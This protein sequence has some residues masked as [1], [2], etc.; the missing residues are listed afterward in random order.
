MSKL[1]EYYKEF[2]NENKKLKMKQKWMSDFS[3]ALPSQ[4]NVNWDHATYH[5]NKGTPPKEA[6]KTH[7]PVKGR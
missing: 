5:F 2:V 6:A 7:T 1:L 3:D 4:K